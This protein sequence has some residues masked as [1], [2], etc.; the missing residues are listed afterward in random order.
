MECQEFNRLRGKGANRVIEELKEI[1][2]IT[3]Q[4]GPDDDSGPSDLP[5]LDSSKF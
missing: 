4:Q 3:A 2:T 1:D 5:Q